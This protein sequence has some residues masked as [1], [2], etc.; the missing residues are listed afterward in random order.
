MSNVLM[1]T[2]MALLISGT[3]VGSAAAGWK[4]KFSP[5]LLDWAMIGGGLILCYVSIYLIRLEG[6]RARQSEDAFLSELKVA[7]DDLTMSDSEER[8]E[9]LCL[10]Y[11]EGERKEIL[12]RLGRIPKGQRKL[13]VVLE[14]MKSESV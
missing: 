13:R 5:R 14:Q 10:L 6:K 12:D 3:L 2:G 1:I 8:L 7:A 9:D 11:D 4:L